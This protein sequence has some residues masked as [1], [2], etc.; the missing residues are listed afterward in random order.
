[1]RAK[2]RLSR[3]PWKLIQK[4]HMKVDDGGKT[5]VELTMMGGN[6]N[7]GVDIIRDRI[8]MLLYTRLVVGLGLGFQ[9]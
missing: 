3:G 1:M 4:P 7:Q 9:W 2:E 8:L 6:R 5:G